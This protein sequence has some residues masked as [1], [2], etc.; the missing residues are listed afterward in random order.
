MANMREQLHKLVDSLPDQSLEHA[1]AA[2][3][4]CANPEQQRMG[5]EKAKEHLLQR[6]QEAQRRHFE[7][8]GKG[9]VSS[10]GSGGGMTF[11]DGTHHSSMIAFEEGKEVTI[12][13]YVYRGTP[14]EIIETMEM[15]EDGQRLIRRE[16]LKGNDGSE[17]LLTAELPVSR[18]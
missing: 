8:L 4:Y 3:L 16:R 13:F 14:F 9:F 15:S 1:K 10:V 18:K 2:L 6:S 11:V 5:I 12:H 7:R 17:Q